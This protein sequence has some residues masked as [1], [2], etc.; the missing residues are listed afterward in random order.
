MTALDQLGPLELHHIGIVV[1]DID[2]ATEQYRALGFTGG[3]KTE[4]T[5]QGVIAVAF[6]AG[7]GWV[8]LIQ[9]T[10][11]DGAI[12]KFLAKRGDGMHH[13][14]YRVPDLE[15]ALAALGAAGVRLIDQA[16]R[17]GLHGWRVAFIHPEACNGVLTE[18][19]DDSAGAH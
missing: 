15:G 2:A 12:A 16:P 13:V 17:Q 14:A 3:E 4:V 7:A 10:N 6:P 18:L 1:A 11:P 8:E 9:P 5:E 19:I